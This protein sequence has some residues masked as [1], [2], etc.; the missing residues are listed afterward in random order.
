VTAALTFSLAGDADLF[1]D[2]VVAD[3]KKFA[4][5]TKLVILYITNKSKID[6]LLRFRGAV[7][8]SDV[9][10]IEAVYVLKNDEVSDYFIDRKKAK[11]LT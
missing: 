3:V 7:R 4:L 10:N 8:A 1:D 6:D 9:K 11:T 2:V 5:F